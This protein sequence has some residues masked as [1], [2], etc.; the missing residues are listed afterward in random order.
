MSS[1]NNL[2]DKAIL[3]MPYD[4]INEDFPNVNDKIHN[5]IINCVKLYRR[6]KKRNC[7]G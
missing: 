3:E 2:E 7:N 1:I 4:I 5:Q 6:I